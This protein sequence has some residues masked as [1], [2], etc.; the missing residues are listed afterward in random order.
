MLLFSS[1]IYDSCTC[2]EDWQD[3]LKDLIVKLN[4]SVAFDAIAGDMSGT[5]MQVANDIKRFFILSTSKFFNGAMIQLLPEGS[6]TV[7]YGGLSGRLVI[8]F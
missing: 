2:R 5:I 7:V 4:I 6:T 3:Q 8:G 1:G